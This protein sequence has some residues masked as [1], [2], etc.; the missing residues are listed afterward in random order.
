MNLISFT[1]LLTLGKALFSKRL[2]RFLFYILGSILSLFLLIIFLLLVRLSFSPIN[3]DFLTPDIEANLNIPQ[4][5][6][7]GKISQTQLVWREWTSPFEIELQKVYLQKDANPNW[8]EIDHV[9]IAL[10]LL[11]LMM[12][13]VSLKQVRFHNPYILLEKQEDG[14]FSLGLG[15]NKPEEDF[16]LK[17]LLPFLALGG[18]ST[19]LGKL[20]DLSSISVIDAH[21]Q[22]SNSKENQ[23][24]Q[25]PKASFLLKRE[26]SGFEFSIK[27]IP[28]QGSGSLILTLDHQLG[29]SRVD[30]SL[31]LKNIS[32]EKLFENKGISICSPQTEITTLDDFLNFLQCWD[33]SLNGK[34]NLAFKPET[35][36][37][38]DAK[39]DVTL[40]K[41]SVDLSIAKI[42]PLPLQ[43]GDISFTLTSGAFLL[44]KVALISDSMKLNVMGEI[45]AK[46]SFFL[47]NFFDGIDAITLQGEMEDLP[48]DHI[49]ALWP[50]NVSINARE[51]ITK[52]LHV[53][54]MTEATF[55]LKAHKEETGFSVNELKGT[56]KG[57]DA[58][59][60]YL[61]GMPP[62]Q[63]VSVQGTFD[64]KSFDFTLFSGNIDYIEVEKGH[65]LISGLDTGKEALSLEIE[66]EG[67]L[68][69]ILKVIDNKPLEYASY[70]GVDPK[71][72]KGEGSINLKMNFPLINNLKFKDIKITASGKFQKVS[73]ERQITT[74]LKAQLMQGDLSFN[75]TQDKLEIKGKGVLN[76]LPA[77]LLYTHYFKNQNPN[78][79]E[80]QVD[81]KA[82]FDDFKR[83]GFDYTE[84][85]QG[86]TNTQLTYQRTTTGQNKVAIDLDTTAADLVFQPLGWEKKPGEESRISFIFLID[87]EKLS[88]INPIQF[89]SPTYSF[90]GDVFFDN[91]GEWEQIHLSDF[92]GPFTDTQVNI[93]K[94]GQNAYEIGFKGRSVNLEN[95]LKLLD[96]D[97]KKQEHPPTHLKLSA[98]VG[99]L[100]LG[101]DRVFNSINGFANLFIV[102]N[103]TYWKEVHFTAQAG[104]G[105]ANKGQMSQVSGGISFD[106]HA[107]QGEMQSLEVR[108]NDAGI[109]LKN[110]DI[111]Q[112][113][114]GGYITIKAKRKN[115]GPFSG[116]FKMKNFDALEVPVLAQFAALLSPMGIANLLSGG[117]TLSMESFEC[118]FEFGDEFVKVQKGIGKSMS[119]GFTVDGNLNRKKRLFSL[120]GNVIPARFLNSILSNIPIIG[121][122]LNGGEGQGMFAISYTVTGAFDTP[123]I[124]LNPLTAL[125]PGF[126]RNL[127]TFSDD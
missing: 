17:E 53:G 56:L 98:D 2:F 32:I 26:N 23:T 41:G 108:A 70:G 74:N 106:L 101:E 5:G 64:K 92:K 43:S 49:A 27:L 90:L 78:E 99:A 113:I 63:N 69:N 119:L 75:L 102:G 110:L 11:R 122:L 25:L 85:A 88:K 48:L 125:A 38:I 19:A 115:Q 22:L 87:N 105:T 30:A 36:E 15:K 37:I 71:K 7:K 77:T 116:I 54:L 66:T 79:I 127:F 68:S 52:N 61:E 124:S 14:G 118:S 40:G 18:S 6:I 50:Q 28:H 109:F 13:E 114:K 97:T 9:G 104:Q 44:K 121:P 29:S 93:Q 45:K 3:L 107:P 57:K 72:V 51:W 42:L 117:H 96:D 24:W 76:K 126:I 86:P 89:T 16:S 83:L 111:Y 60:S 34:I 82:S 62:A 4:V 91:G 1:P 67:S 103:D 10:R 59:I 46:S 80:I 81:T 8:L 95:I 100:R 33:L 12:G 112:G 35:Y 123:E 55:S 65:V 94:L 31:K 58:E 73:L 20:N 39:G 84:Y 47:T 21:I 120:K